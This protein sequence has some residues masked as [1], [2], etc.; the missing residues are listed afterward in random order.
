MPVT[1]TGADFEFVEKAAL[2]VK[3][4]KKRPGPG[5]IAPPRD[6]TFT[7]PLGKRAGE[8]RSIEVNVDTATPGAYLLALTQ[9][10]GVK[11]EAPVVFFRPT[12][13]SRTCQSA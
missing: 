8:Q 4:P 2:E 5:K 10:D 11:H 1:L 3:P 6:L 7:L 13:R 12:P 9:S